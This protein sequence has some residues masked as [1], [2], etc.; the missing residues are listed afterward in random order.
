MARRRAPPRRRR[1]RHAAAALTTLAVLALLEGAAR[2]FEPAIPRWEAGSAEGL[3]MTAHA[4]R[5][6]ALPPGALKNG[7]HV[8]HIGANGLRLP[9]APPSETVDQ[10]RVLVLGDSSFFGHALADNE[11]LAVQL[12]AALDARGVPA[13]G[14]NGAVPGYSTA[15]TRVLLAEVGWSLEPDLLVLGNLWSDNS[16]DAFEDADLLRTSALFAAN[17]LSRSALFRVTAAWVANARG[18]GPRVI[19]WT[20]DSRWPTRRIRRVPLWDYAANLDLIVHEARDRNVGVVFIAPVNRAMAD[21]LDA[22]SGHGWDPYF[23]AQK[24]V[25]EWHGLPLV[26]GTDAIRATG[27]S[28]ADAFVDVMHPSAAGVHAIAEAT[29]AALVTRGWPK[30]R[31]PGRAE[32]YVP[33]DLYDFQQSTETGQSARFS[34]QSPL[35]AGADQAGTGAAAVVA[36]GTITG[37]APPY[38]VAVIDAAGTRWTG[39]EVSAPGAFSLSCPGDIG[40]AELVFTDAGGH[41]E[42]RPLDPQQLLVAVE[43]AD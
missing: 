24:Q 25:A 29:A 20:R 23:Q 32:A 9:C 21:G 22:G 36:S 17:P 27:L 40:V 42:Q 35:F 19:G 13:A 41:T 30:E 8:A 37:G 14:L 26:S 6:W 38:Q 2:G 31:L 43:F 11:T 1:F 7:E 10:K 4:T 3:T 12:D 16:A 18:G 39:V 33:R 15:Q 34:A 5:L 28:G